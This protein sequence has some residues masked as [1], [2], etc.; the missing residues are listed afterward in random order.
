MLDTVKTEV[1]SQTGDQAKLKVSYQMFDQP[2]SFETEL[3]QID[4]RW[5]GKQAIAELE[6]PDEDEAPAEPASEAPATEG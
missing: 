3:V 2:M 6:K 5:Y 4:G 1:V